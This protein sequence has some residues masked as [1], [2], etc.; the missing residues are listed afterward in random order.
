MMNPIDFHLSTTTE[1]LFHQPFTPGQGPDSI[2]N[3]ENHRTC[4]FSW[5]HSRFFDRKTH[6]FSLVETSEF[7]TT[8]PAP[9]QLCEETRKAEL[10]VT[11]A[12]GLMIASGNDYQFANFNMAIEI[13]AL[14]I[15]LGGFFHSYPT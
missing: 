15:E 4:H 14:P 1:I 12:D 10:M 11:E 2:S 3:W 8:N 7:S 5:I 13:V 9:G 6:Q